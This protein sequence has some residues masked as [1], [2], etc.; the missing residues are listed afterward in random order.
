[1]LLLAVHGA[2]LPEPRRVPRAVSAVEVRINAT[3]QALQPHAGGLIQI[4]S[5]P[6]DGEVRYD[7]GIGVRNPDT[8]A[9]VYYNLAGAYDSNIALV[10]TDGENRRHSYERV[11]EILRRTA[12]RG[13]DLHTN[14][15]V[16]Y[17]LVNWF[18]GKGP[19]AEPDTNFMRPYLAAVG[20]LQ[21]IVAGVDLGVAMDALRGRQPDENARAVLDR[22]ETLLLR[23]LERLLVDPHALGGFLGRFDGVLWEREEREVCFAANP[24]HFL[25]E[26]YRYLDLEEVPGKPPSEKIWDHDDEILQ[27]GL[28]FYERV[29]ELTGVAGWR[30][31]C[32]LLEG[33]RDDRVV[34]GDDALWD[35]C[36]AAHRGFQVGLELLLTIPRI[37]VVSG[38]SDVTVD[39]ELN[40]IFPSRF[41]DDEIAA[42]CIG[43]LAPP[44]VAGADEIV[45]PMGGTYYAREAPHLPAMIEV[46]DH[47]QVGQPLF[48]V[49]VMKMFN[50]VTAPFAGTITERLMAGKDGTVVAKGQPIFRIDPDDRIDVES[51]ET[52]IERTREVTLSFL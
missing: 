50:K 48:V 32:A 20:A 26:L 35:A 10:V 7:Q 14:L 37:G 11:A 38:F 9:F 30:E 4:W 6:I 18:L 49:E 12:L 33:D 17:G 5:E 46:G 45:S 8:G 52:R 40:V 2:R 34:G 42:E 21:Q 47:C 29:T 23:P 25:L 41:R 24:I 39:V 16:H 27:E 44:P 51:E 22:K 36:R 3:N 19:M 28:G 15:S 13:E 43:A 31:M 1:M